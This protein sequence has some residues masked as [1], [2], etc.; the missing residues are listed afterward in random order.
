MVGSFR[1]C[2]LDFALLSFNKN[3]FRI[4]QWTLKITS[5]AANSKAEFDRIFRTTRIESLTRRKNDVSFGVIMR[6][7]SSHGILRTES[8][9]L[10]FK[11]A[12]TCPDKQER[13]SDK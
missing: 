4:E 12:E 2:E 3:S 10:L 8:C 7:G 6:T 13:P 1:S 5:W 9:L 11:V